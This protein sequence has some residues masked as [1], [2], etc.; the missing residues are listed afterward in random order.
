MVSK[1]VTARQRGDVEHWIWYYSEEHQGAHYLGGFGGIIWVIF[2]FFLYLSLVCLPMCN[3]IW[4]AAISLHYSRHSES[5]KGRL[6]KKSGLSLA[7]LCV[8]LTLREADACPFQRD[9]FHKKELPS[10]D[11]L[12]SQVWLAGASQLNWRGRHSASVTYSRSVYAE[13][14]IILYMM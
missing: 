2:Q 9:G 3:D 6:S 5:F 7:P 11:L 13:Q 4:I 1:E 10:S 14:K 8:P 12:W